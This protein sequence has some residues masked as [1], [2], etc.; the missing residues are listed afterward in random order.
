VKE[1]GENDRNMSDTST[2]GSRALEI[3]WNK[4]NRQ[5]PGTT[6]QGGV[7]PR[8]PRE[9]KGLEDRGRNPHEGGMGTTLPSGEKDGVHY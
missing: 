1:E 8:K 5:H 6:H 4:K 3:E 7:N 9:K 2:S